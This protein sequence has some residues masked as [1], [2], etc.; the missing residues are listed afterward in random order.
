[1]VVIR[2]HTT[3]EDVKAAQPETI[4]YGYNTRW[5][6]HR[7]EDVFS[8]DGTHSGMPCDPRGGMLMMGPA[9]DFLAAAEGDPDFFGSH[10]LD[11]FIGAHND[12]C[13]VSDADPRST[14]LRDWKDYNL[15]LDSQEAEV[16]L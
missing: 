12:N 5:W 14:C 1:M 10:G 4:W 7:A 3:L 2:Q 6:T 16:E 8:H 13:L 15:I 11:A 9:A